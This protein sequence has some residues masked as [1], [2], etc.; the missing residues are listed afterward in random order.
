MKSFLKKYVHKFRYAFQGL[1]HGLCYD[2]SILLQALIGAVVIVWCLFLSLS[3]L[4]WTIILSMILLV[5]A[6]EFVNSTI[7]ELCDVLFPAYDPRA[8]K[9]KDYA[10]AAVLLISGIA[11][12]S[13]LYIIGGALW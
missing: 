10:A 1:F 12:M 8:K 9:I 5:L 11:A 13:G 2:H 4:E 6:A 3:W 7:E